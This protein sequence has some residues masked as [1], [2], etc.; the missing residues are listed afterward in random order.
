MRS[1][2]FHSKNNQQHRLE[3]QLFFP[4]VFLRHFLKSHINKWHG[5][6][7]K[8]SQQFTSFPINFISLFH[9][10]S[11]H[12]ISSL[13]CFL[14]CR[15]CVYIADPLN[16]HQKYIKVIKCVIAW[17]HCNWEMIFNTSLML[18]F[19]ILKLIKLLTWCA[20]IFRCWSA[21]DGG[22]KKK[23]ETTR[24]M[25]YL[26]QHFERHN[27]FFL[28]NVQ[29]HILKKYLNLNCECQSLAAV[30]ETELIDV[31]RCQKYPADCV[32]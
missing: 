16:L 24:M 22:K 21:F 28:V 15:E 11:S 7:K 6:L 30:N 26:N 25:I 32:N 17:S 5:I 19:I 8:H 3:S 4:F 10:C 14:A 31:F 9:F 12:L 2:H 18:I 27:N 29:L 23:T 20:I 1:K 13:H